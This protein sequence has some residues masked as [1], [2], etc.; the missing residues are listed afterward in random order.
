MFADIS[1]GCLRLPERLCA[2]A[3]AGQAFSQAPVLPAQLLVDAQ[4]LRDCDSAGIAAL[5]WLLRHG[6]QQ[7]VRI[8]WQGFSP[9]LQLLPHLYDVDTQ[10][11][12]NDARA[13]N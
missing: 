13:A 8:V 4:A 7:A 9:Q 2:Q 3:L 1:D 11:S 10:G 5:L 6:R 12:I